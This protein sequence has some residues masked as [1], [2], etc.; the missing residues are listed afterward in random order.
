MI[1]FHLGDMMILPH[2]YNSNSF[3][4]LTCFSRILMF[5]HKMRILTLLLTPKTEWSNH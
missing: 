2:F 5:Q 4:I 1:Q 3:L